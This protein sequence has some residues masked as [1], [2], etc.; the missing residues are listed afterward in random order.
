M[1]IDFGFKINLSFTNNIKI[2]TTLYTAFTNDKH[3]LGVNLIN[4][5][6]SFI[7]NIAYVPKISYSITANDRLDAS[8]TIAG[9]LIRLN[10]HNQDMGLY[11]YSDDDPKPET[12]SDIGVGAKIDFYKK[13]ISLGLFNQKLAT[14]LATGP[15]KIDGSTSLASLS[16]NI[17]ESNI[18]DMTLEKDFKQ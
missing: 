18:A 1:K 15:D 3:G 13:T 9:N 16:P 4:N 11:K 12:I 8:A 2:K 7:A 6:S 5:R 17:M 14:K 10:I